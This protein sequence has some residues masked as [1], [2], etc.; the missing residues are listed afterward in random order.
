MYGII[1][2]TLI[3]TSPGAD[4]AFAPPQGFSGDYLAFMRERYRLDPGVR[5]HV[6]IVGRMVLRGDKVSFTG[7][8]AN[9]ARRL[10]GRFN[11]GKE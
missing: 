8:F 6:A 4:T 10:V 7:Q 3:D 11:K 9:Q 1:D 5:Q 2:F